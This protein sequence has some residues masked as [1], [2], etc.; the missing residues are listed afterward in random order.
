MWFEYLAKSNVPIHLFIDVCSAPFVIHLLDHSNIYIE[1][2]DNIKNTWTYRVCESYTNKLPRVRLVEKDTFEYLTLM[3]TKSEFVDRAARA[4]IFNTPQFAW[5]DFNIF[6]VIKNNDLSIA[7]LK[8]IAQCRLAKDINILFPGCWS[9]GTKC[10]ELW[11]AINWR[12]CGTFHIGTR[13]GVIDM[14]E[15]IKYN[16]ANMLYLQDGL[17]WE[18][19]IWAH[20]EHT[21]NWKP[22]WY[23]S[24]HND[25]LF[26]IPECLIS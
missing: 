6:H 22:S 25:K 21:T 2:V 10:D 17:T 4:N 24:N 20:L 1:I 23:A 7:N 5:I 11:K 8:K 13:E 9:A 15:R 16:L 12:F 26:E 19:N 3:N 14:Q 18:V